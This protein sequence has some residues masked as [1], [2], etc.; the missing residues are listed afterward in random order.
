[1]DTY[2][3]SALNREPVLKFTDTAKVFAGETIEIA[4]SG[5]ANYG[6]PAQTYSFDYFVA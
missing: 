4:V 5:T 3:A 1:M 2:V 6:D